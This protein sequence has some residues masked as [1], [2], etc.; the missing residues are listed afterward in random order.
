ME[1]GVDIVKISRIKRVYEIYD[2]RFLKNIFHPQEQAALQSKKS[3]SCKSAYLSKRFAAK[4]AL[5][6][7]TG[8]IIAAWNAIAVLNN[9]NGSPFV[10]IDKK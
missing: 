4:E 1:I 5:F 8:K 3:L 9:E 2:Q 6:K 7:A 10:K